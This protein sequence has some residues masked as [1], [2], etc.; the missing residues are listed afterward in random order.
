M[1]AKHRR[2]P[3]QDRRLTTN[4][5][6]RN[7]KKA[8]SKDW[9]SQTNPAD[10]AFAAGPLPSCLLPRREGKITWV[11]AAQSSIDRIQRADV[12]DLDVK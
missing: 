8:G 1:T 9:E 5:H 3:L 12:V 6:E 4:Q 7:G 10:K 11:C 2:V